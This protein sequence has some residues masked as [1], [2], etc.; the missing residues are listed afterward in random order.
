MSKTER[1]VLFERAINNGWAEGQVKSAYFD[2]SVG[3][4]DELVC[5]A[6]SYPVSALCQLCGGCVDGGDGVRCIC[7]RKS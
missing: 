3:L 6:E 2:A 1:D 5:M 7:W 4:D